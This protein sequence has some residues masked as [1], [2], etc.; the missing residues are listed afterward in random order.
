MFSNLLQLSSP[1]G[2]TLGEFLDGDPFKWTVSVKACGWFKL[3][4]VATSA[5]TLDSEEPLRS[6]RNILNFLLVHFILAGSL[7][8]S[9][10][11]PGSE[12][13][14]EMLTA[15]TVV[16]RKWDDWS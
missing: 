5:C 13:N 10:L 7:R 2:K 9:V 16:S 15:V 12:N 1:L 14:G 4:D 11:G 3:G 6:W 8:D